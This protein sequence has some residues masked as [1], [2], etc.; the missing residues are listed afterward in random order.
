[1][2]FIEF[3]TDPGISTDDPRF[4]GAWWLGFLICAVVN[5][6]VAFPISLFPADVKTK[7]Q[8]MAEEETPEAGENGD[9][10]PAEQNALGDFKGR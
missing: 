3:C 6:L 7:K 8:K 9:T 10:K 1:M 4:I 5:L 2:I